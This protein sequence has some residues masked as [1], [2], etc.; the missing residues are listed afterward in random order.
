ME[1]DAEHLTEHGMELVS[2]ACRLADS[3]AVPSSAVHLPAALARIGDALD[4]LSLALER[5]PHSL[6]PPGRPQEP[7]CRRFDRAADA[8]P[9][10]HGCEGPSYERQ[11]Q[12]LSSLY[13][14]GATLRMSR[15]A[16][17]RA[18][19]L[20]IDMTM[21]DDRAAHLRHEASTALG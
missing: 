12:L 17:A 8:W 18:N 4:A 7:V 2:A 20:L 5:A 1:P 16:C 3:V 6:V 9:A 14:A 10:T 15:R 11:A 19:G 13:E 21:S